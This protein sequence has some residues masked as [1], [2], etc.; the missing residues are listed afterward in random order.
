[1]SDYTSNSTPQQIASWLKSRKKVIV[2]THAKPDGDALG[3]TTGL[4]RALAH[5]GI[6]AEIWLIGPCPTWTDAVV[7]STPVKKLSSEATQ[8][9]ASGA[10]ADG[11]AICDTGSWNQLEGLRP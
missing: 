1:M 9:P 4:C 2:C 6:P 11:I 5:A 10:D 7:G 3:S 8:I